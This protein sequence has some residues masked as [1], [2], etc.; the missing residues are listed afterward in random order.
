MLSPLCLV[1][2]TVGYE[3]IQSLVH[4]T[5]PHLQVSLGAFQPLGA[6]SESQGQASN[7]REML[8]MPKGHQEL[9]FPVMRTG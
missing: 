7:C 3:S 8:S 4:T 2:E 6:F 9:W 5:V 1:T